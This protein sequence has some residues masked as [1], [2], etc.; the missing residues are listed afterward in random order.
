MSLSESDLTDIE[1]SL[2]ESLP[3]PPAMAKLQ[4]SNIWIIEWLS[5]GETQTGQKL[6]EWMKDQRPGWSRYQYCKTK[7]EV[8][9]A[10]ERATHYSQQSGMIP[11]LHLEAHGG[12]MGL[13]PSNCV[14]AEFLTWEELTYPLQQLNLATRCN[15]LVVAISRSSAS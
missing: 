4:F 14:D 5:P 10:I 12:D 15:L 9:Q 13:A 2:I 3:T 11:V 7:S 6:H 8:I 1:Q